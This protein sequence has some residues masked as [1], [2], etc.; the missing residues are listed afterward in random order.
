MPACRSCN[1]AKGQF[2]GP[3]QHY[4]LIDVHASMHPEAQHLFDTKL[5]KAVSTNRVRL[6]DRY[7]EGRSVSEIT[8]NGLW[9]RENYE[10][11]ID[12]EP[13]RQAL[14]YLVRGLHYAVFGEVKQP[15][16]VGANIVSRGERRGFADS[17]IQLGI[18]GFHTQGNVLSVAWMSRAATNVYWMFDFFDR[19]LCMGRSAKTN[20][21]Y[22]PPIPQDLRFQEVGPPAGGDDASLPLVEPS[23]DEAKPVLPVRI[24]QARE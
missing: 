4:V 6:L 2:D 3:L 15:D 8:A 22:G 11:P 12:F 1:E 5:A 21:L 23:M 24:E 17:F 18:D 14:I 20:P 9:V 16:E 13:I 7:H 19:I 10:V